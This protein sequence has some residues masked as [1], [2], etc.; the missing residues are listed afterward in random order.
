MARPQRS[1]EG[2]AG[3]SLLRLVVKVSAQHFVRHAVRMKLSAWCMLLLRL[4]DA[5][6][7]ETV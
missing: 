5:R 6:I 3:A 4:V 2:V 7:A 1:A